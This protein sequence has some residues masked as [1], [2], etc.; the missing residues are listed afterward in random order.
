MDL[1]IE[2][3][4][5]DIA[6]LDNV[7]FPFEPQEALVLAARDPIMGGKIVVGHR[8]R[9]DEA[10]FEVGVDDAGGLR[11]CHAPG[12]RPGLGLLFTCPSDTFF[13]PNSNPSHIGIETYMHAEI[14]PT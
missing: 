7:L 9:T 13:K 14:V 8:L 4:V 12:D 3:E 6:L 1:N 2:P 5:H 10:L 11:G